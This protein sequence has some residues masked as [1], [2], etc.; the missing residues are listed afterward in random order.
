MWNLTILDLLGNV[1]PHHSGHLGE[2]GTSLFLISWGMWNPTILDTLGNVEPLYSGHLGEC[3]TVLINKVSSCKGLASQYLLMITQ[4]VSR[5]VLIN[6]GSSFQGF[7]LEGF[8]CMH[9]NFSL[10]PS[11]LSCHSMPCIHD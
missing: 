1:E 2:C 8:H 5:S 6:E 4:S 3:G 10:S 11:S 7:G 9:T